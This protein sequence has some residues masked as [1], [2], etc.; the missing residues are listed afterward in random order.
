MSPNS[1]L[2]FRC[3]LTLNHRF[4]SSEGRS[5]AFDH[6]ASGYGRGE[7]VACIVIKPL[8]KALRDGDYIHSVIRQ[9]AVNSDG[10]TDGITQPSAVAHER[11][12]RYAYNEVNLDPFETDYV[13]CHGTGTQA[14]DPLELQ[15]V[16]KVFG[17][18]RTERN[19]VYIGSVKTNVGHLEAASGLAGVIKASMSMQKGVLP[20]NINFEKVNDK[21][22]LEKY[23]LKVSVLCVYST[24]EKL[25]SRRFHFSKLLGLH[26]M[27]LAVLR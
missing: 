7:G 6:R 19:P 27:G 24:C 22:P 26:Q 4:L 1:K 3:V 2:E 8:D 10:R 23:H 25:I 16:G 18:T 15:A 20:P 12:L 9:T 17:G 5:Y 14:G 11:L 13:E 21:I